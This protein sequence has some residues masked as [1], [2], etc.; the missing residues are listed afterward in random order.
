M[1]WENAERKHFFDNF[2]SL[3][4]GQEAAAD[5]WFL[6]HYCSA[7]MRAQLKES[8]VDTR[9]ARHVIARIA[10]IV[11]AGDHSSPGWNG[12]ALPFLVVGRGRLQS[13]AK[14]RKRF[15]EDIPDRRMVMV[16]S[17]PRFGLCIIE[18]Q[19]YVWA[20]KADVR[21][22]GLPDKCWTEWR[23]S[24]QLRYKIPVDLPNQNDGLH[25][26]SGKHPLVNFLQRI[27]LKFEA[28]DEIIPRVTTLTKIDLD[29]PE[30]FSVIY[31]RLLD[32]ISGNGDGHSNE[33]ALNQQPDIQTPI[34]VPS[35]MRRPSSADSMLQV[36]RDLAIA[37]VRQVIDTFD[38]ARLNKWIMSTG[39]AGA[40][41]P[42]QNTADLFHVYAASLT[43]AG[44]VKPNPEAFGEM[45]GRVIRQRLGDGN[46]LQA[47]P[48]LPE[49]AK[50]CRSLSQDL[51]LG[52]N[53]ALDIA[54]IADNSPPHRPLMIGL[55]RSVLKFWEWLQEHHQG[56]AATMHQ[57]FLTQ[58]NVAPSQQVF[59][60]L[61]DLDRLP[62][63]GIATAANFVKDSQVP[64]L[65]TVCLSPAETA[66]HLAGWFVKPDLHV[67]RLMAYITGRYTTHD[68]RGLKQSQALMTFLSDPRENFQG[69]Y[70]NL[71]RA[72]SLEL[73]VVADV[74]EWAVA[75]RT[76]PLEIDRLLFL[77]GVQETRVEGVSVS[78]P[79]YTHFMSEVDAALARSVSRKS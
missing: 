16:I 79:W 23:S 1:T 32:E 12:T 20:A 52:G 39:Y 13:R 31:P 47:V 37:R 30:G 35:V 21:E 46:T 78:S 53:F 34:A 54:Q 65:Q 57:V 56:C 62:W 24:D 17:Q 49:L 18:K 48:D 61:R 10:E 70:Q 22:Q 36:L 40:K 27:A 5:E 9:I 44:G 76:S 8:G 71:L 2:N 15:P 29:E 67:S 45:I 55:L 75:A 43:N 33:N 77:I 11:P 58:T 26:L 41:S 42:H 51:V 4:E 73:Q 3:V 60:C 7:R 59:D 68:L 14:W 64:G 25:P 72:D 6:T 66:Q 63:M 28:L 74:H 50:Q 38:Q 19:L 69:R